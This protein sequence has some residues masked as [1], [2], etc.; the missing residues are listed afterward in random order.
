MSDPSTPEQPP[1]FAQL[2]DLGVWI[3]AALLVLASAAILAFPL[4]PEWLRVQT[5]H[6]EAWGAVS[7]AWSVWLLARNNPLGWIVG[8]VGVALYAWVF[9]EAQLY[10]EVGLQCFYFVTSLQAIWIW[11]RGGPAHEER[12]VGRVQPATLGWTALA[13]VAASAALTW[14]LAQARG[15]VPAVDAFTTVVSVT[16]HLYLMGRYVE[17]WYLW[18]AVDAIYVPLYFTR[19][20]SLTAALYAL[21]WVLAVQGMLRFRRLYREQTRGPAP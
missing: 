20:L 13:V 19:G 18:V 16:A 8:L 17:S 11:A 12:P 15:A 1:E 5:S 14:V 6:N 21:F 7:L 9:W 4:Y 3:E 10:G 2:P